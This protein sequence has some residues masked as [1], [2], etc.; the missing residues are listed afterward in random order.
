M[1]NYSMASYRTVLVYNQFKSNE[2]G[3]LCSTQWLPPFHFI[4][5]TQNSA[6]NKNEM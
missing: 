3:T 4:G 1:L 2:I 6:M 5:T